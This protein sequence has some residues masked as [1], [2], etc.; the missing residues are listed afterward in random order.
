MTAYAPPWILVDELEQARVPYELIFHRRTDSALDEAR[1]L[2]VPPSQVAKTIVLVTP[3]GFVR[4]VLPASARL[5]LRKVRHA[6]AAADAR[7]ATEQELVGA[8]PEFELGAVPPFVL[9]GGDTVLVDIRLCG[10]DELLVEAGTH[11]QSLRLATRDVLEL[12][13]ATLGDICIDAP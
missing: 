12:A 6:L 4:A 3:D 5:D 1:V 11:E 10:S 8:Y 2:A 9:A 13:Q 7:L